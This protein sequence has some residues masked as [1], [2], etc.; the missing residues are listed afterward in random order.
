MVED[1]RP[2]DLRIGKY[3]DTRIPLW[4]LLGA[5]GTFAML[6]AGMYFQLNKLIEDVTDVKI[7]VKSGNQAQATMQGELA[8][9]RFR[10]ETLEADKR[11]RNGG[12]YTNGSK[13]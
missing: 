6:I 10:I 9:L 2:G 4:Q 8:I 3:I 13:E 5:V 1:T 11:A 12:G 7:A